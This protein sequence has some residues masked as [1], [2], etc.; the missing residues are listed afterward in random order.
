LSEIH[1][2]LFFAIITAELP[3]L[4][5]VFKAAR[6]FKK[7]ASGKAIKIFIAFLRKSY[8]IGIPVSETLSRA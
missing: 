4:W 7:S 5:I 2:S 8:T 6:F 1:K 3:L